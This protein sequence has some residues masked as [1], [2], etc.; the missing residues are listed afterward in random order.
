MGDRPPTSAHARGPQQRAENSSIE[1]MG[2]AE[3][4]QLAREH[5]DPLPLLEQA[6]RTVFDAS[7]R[8]SHRK[9]AKTLR[10]AVR[11][12]DRYLEPTHTPG[13]AVGW[14]V[15]RMREDDEAGRRPHS[16]AFYVQRLDFESRDWRR[17]AKVE[18]AMLVEAIA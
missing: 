11:R 13:A 17:Y 1:R 8:L 3:I 18:R 14:L 9:W 16:L 15:D 5:G 7:P 4:R 10:C 12:G 6:F 2:L